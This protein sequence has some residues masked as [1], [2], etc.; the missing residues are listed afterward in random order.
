MTEPADK[1]VYDD[2]PDGV[3]V[4]DAEGRVV[5]LNPAAERLLRHHRRRRPRPRL[6]RGPAAG[7]RAGPRLVG[8][9]RPVRRAAAAAPAS[10]SGPDPRRRPRPAGHRRVRP[11]R[12]PR[13]SIRLVVCA[14]RHRRPRAHRAQPRQP[15]Q[16]R[17]PRAA[18]AADLREGLHRDAAREVGALQRR[19]EEGDAADGQ[20]RRRP[21]HPPASPSCSTS[22]ASTPA[23]SRC[24]SRSSTC[25]PPSARSSRAGSPPA[26]PRAASA[27]PRPA[28]LP[29]MWVD[30][31][32]F[33]QVDRQP[34]RERPAPRRGHRH[35]DRRP[36]RRCRAETAPS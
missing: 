22:A 14:A 36:P 23:G 20:R 19:A 21:R 15:R 26:S 6:P 9:H 7:R 28:P 24:A 17:R 27:S 4:A 10:P 32:K 11:R 18:L 31:D 25:P 35:R 5:V 34:R 8:L 2:L 29:E 30:P 13:R 3:L 16:H 33:Q 1:A 12:R